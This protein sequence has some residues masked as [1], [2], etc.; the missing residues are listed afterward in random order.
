M[1]VFTLARYEL[2]PEALADAERAMHAYA[3]YVRGEL[4][5]TVWTTY[6]DP[7]LPGRYFALSRAADPAADQR[8]RDAPG[9]HAF[10]AILAPLLV[11]PPEVADCELVTSSDL[12][13]RHRVDRPAKRRRR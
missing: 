5:G 11:R 9:T 1:A 2:R 3:T 7:S 13:P 8:Q 4:P 12:A 6:R 10:L